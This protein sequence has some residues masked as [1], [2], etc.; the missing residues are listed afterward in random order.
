MPRHFAKII[1]VTVLGLVLSGCSAFQP[2]RSFGRELDD[3]N[4]SISIKSAM[5]RSEGYVMGNV[6]VEVTEGLVLLTGTAPRIADRLHAEC[7]AWSVPQVRDVSNE[8]EIGR[9][10]GMGS[11][12]RDAVITQQIR[13]RIVSDSEVAG[14]NFNIETYDGVVY[15]LG[16][17]RNSAER[18]RVARHASLVDD[19]EQVV[20][21]VR[22]AGEQPDLP[23]RG[24][25]IAEICSVEGVDAED[26]A[27]PPAE[28][29]PI[30]PTPLG[31]P[32][33]E[34]DVIEPHEDVP[35]SQ[36]SNGGP[37]RL[38]E[39]RLPDVDSDVPF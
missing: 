32:P 12:A 21:M 4:A 8:V 18:E 9:A 11:A 28:Y 16:F 13:S 14:R 23:P 25:R 31:A 2:G 26:Y 3:V 15:L 30:E 38:A 22:L 37:E 5:L 35:V 17:A 10:R 27:P 20:V 33:V 1:T 24:E 19:V 39:P 7:L 36:P 34:R 6:D 29:T